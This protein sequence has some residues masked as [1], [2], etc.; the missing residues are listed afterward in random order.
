MRLEHHDLE[1]LL[2]Y[3]SRLNVSWEERARILLQQRDAINPLLNKYSA[4][5]SD[6][7]EQVS[8][9]QVVG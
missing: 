2:D 5:F 8:H 6:Y 9:W 3:L 4:T 1:G 7:F